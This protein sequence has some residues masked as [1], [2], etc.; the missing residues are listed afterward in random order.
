MGLVSKNT[1]K[2][3]LYFLSFIYFAASITIIVFGI[4][5]FSGFTQSYELKDFKQDVKIADNPLAKMCTLIG[6][7]AGLIMAI[8]LFLSAKWR[9]GIFACPF[10]LLGLIGGAIL[11][12]AFTF[13]VKTKD[14][15][16]YKDAVC[17][18]KF[19]GLGFKTG[20]EVSK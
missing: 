14:P 3:L 10:G 19:A 2:G 15:T 20:T 12:T 18:T 7:L 8:L 11:I 1:S 17:N 6:G 4:I 5:S 9:T 13:A 16:F